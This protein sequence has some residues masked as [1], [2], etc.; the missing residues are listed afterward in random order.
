MK[1]IEK[2]QKRNRLRT[3]VSKMV[4]LRVGLTSVTKNKRFFETFSVQISAVADLKGARGTRAPRGP[5]SF[6]FMQFLG[7]F[8]KIVCWCPLLGEI[9]DLPLIYY[10]YAPLPSQIVCLFHSKIPANNT[11]NYQTIPRTQSTL[12]TIHYLKCALSKTCNPCNVT[13][14]SFIAFHFTAICSHN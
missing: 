3:V 9:L 8:G 4:P 7:K 1:K 14:P 2:R 10:V 6:N 13:G 11:H 12:F 5:N